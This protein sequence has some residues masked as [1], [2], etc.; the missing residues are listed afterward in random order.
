MA[1]SVID[2]VMVFRI[3]RKLTMPYEKWDAFKQGVID[4]KGNILVKSGKRTPN[5]KSSFNL[6]DRLVWNLKKLLGKVPGGS[7][8]LASYIA[9]LALIKEYVEANSNS[10]TSEFLIERLEHDGHIS[11]H[12]LTTREGYWEAMCD[13]IEESMTAGQPGALS[14]MTTNAQA[15]A[16]GLAGPTGPSKEKKKKRKDLTKILDR[17]TV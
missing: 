13:A 1:K 17:Y 8:Q 4:K 14:P 5:Q 9:A 12:D 7:T 15:N 10:E 6:L 3:L 2:T 11:G 16:S